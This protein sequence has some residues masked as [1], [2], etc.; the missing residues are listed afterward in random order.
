MINNLVELSNLAIQVG[1]GKIGYDLAKP[2]LDLLG[3]DLRDRVKKLLIRTSQIR[4]ERG[5]TEDITPKFF[6]PIIQKASLEDDEYLQ[7]MWAELLAHAHDGKFKPSYI[8]ILNELEPLDAKIL[9]FINNSNEIMTIPGERPRTILK[10]RPPFLPRKKQQTP[11]FLRNFESTSEF[12]HRSAAL[13]TLNEHFITAPEVAAPITTSSLH[14][15]L[16][17]LNR[18]GLTKDIRDTHTNE[19]IVL[20]NISE[21]LLRTLAIDH[22]NEKTIIIHPELPEEPLG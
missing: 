18:L 6:V 20:T 3:Q 2:T 15:S 16:D 17:N 9:I 21:N 19:R 4:E 12:T 22:K 8:S 11:S 7:E 5:I 1:A 10:P 13:S 14:D